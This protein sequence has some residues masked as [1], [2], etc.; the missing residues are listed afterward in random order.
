LRS[1]ATD[2][3]LLEILRGIWLRRSDRYSEIRSKV[4]QS[5]EA[6]HKVEMFYIGG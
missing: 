5:E 4:R 3:Q 6:Q 2:Q 1:G